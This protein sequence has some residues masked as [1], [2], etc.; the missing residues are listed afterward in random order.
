MPE[1]YPWHEQVLTA[2]NKDGSRM[3]FLQPLGSPVLRAGADNLINCSDLAFAAIAYDKDPAELTSGSM[4]IAPEGAEIKIDRIRALNAFAV[5]TP[6]IAS[7]KVVAVLDAHLMNINA[8]NTLLKTLEEPPSNTHILLLPSTGAVIANHSQS[9]P[10]LPGASI[11]RSG[12]NLVKPA[13]LVL[14]CPLR[15]SRLYPSQ[16]EINF[17]SLM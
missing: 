13:R 15:P 5:Q 2:I 4:R 10:V 9:M 12:R 16:C 11:G 8:S 6:Q 14:F 17:P 3:R 7:R 1:S